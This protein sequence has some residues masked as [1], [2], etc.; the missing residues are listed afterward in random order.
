MKI[1]GIDGNEIKACCSFLYRGY[2]I[3]ATTISTP[4]EVAIFKLLGS[5]AVIHKCTYVQG[6]IEWIDEQIEAAKHRVQ[7]PLHPGADE[8]FANQCEAGGNGIG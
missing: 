5:D 4:P 3:S 6:A 7:P 1:N 8:A 2:M